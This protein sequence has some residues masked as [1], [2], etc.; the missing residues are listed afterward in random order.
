MKY[1]TKRNKLLMQKNLAIEN[2]MML[3]RY[4][5]LVITLQK[6]EMGIVTIL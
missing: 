2:A 4:Y 1:N 6:E 5:N 3:N